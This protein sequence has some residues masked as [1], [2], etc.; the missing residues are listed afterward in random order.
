M[1][2][3]ISY[4]EEQIRFLKHQLYKERLSNLVH[5]KN[6]SEDED[7]IKYHFNEESDVE[8]KRMV[9][10]L[11]TLDQEFNKLYDK[12]EEKYGDTPN[13][14]S[15]YEIENLQQDISENYGIDFYRMVDLI[16]VL[17]NDDL[18]HIVSCVEEIIEDMKN[19]L[20]NGPDE[21]DE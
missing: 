2:K 4:Y 17:E 9:D 15:F 7:F 6:F 19:D 21:I 3:D 13:S 8:R 14:A 5:N 18:S 10:K 12:Y 16:E 11:Y 1:E 20:I